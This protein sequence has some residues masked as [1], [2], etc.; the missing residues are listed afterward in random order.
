NHQDGVRS[1][2]PGAPILR[3]SIRRDL[4][5]PSIA[6][7][8]RAFEGAGRHGNLI[9][10]AV[11]ERLSEPCG[12]GLGLRLRRAVEPIGEEGKEHAQGERENSE[13]GD[14]LRQR[15]TRLAVG[16]LSW[17][18]RGYPVMHGPAAPFSISRADQSEPARERAKCQK[19][20]ER[21]KSRAVQ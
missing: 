17:C 14:D 9:T 10:H 3:V 7:L 18:L 13:C 5:A 4:E 11:E 1:C 16:A 20:P 21:D 15:E 2:W 8:D 6:V 12:L 19:R